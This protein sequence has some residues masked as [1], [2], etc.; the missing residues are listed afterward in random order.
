MGQLT[1]HTG[2]PRKQA[3]RLIS[4]LFPPVAAATIDRQFGEFVAAARAALSPAALRAQEGAMDGWHA[5]EQPEMP[6]DPPP[7]L[8]AC[9]GEDIVIP[10][11]NSDLLASRWTNCRVERFEGCGHAF[12]AQEPERLADLIT[13]FLR[14]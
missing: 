14:E 8:A 2:T 5:S 12:M 3:T 4:L 6:T 1:D 10:P 13:F 11:E 7:V 9:G